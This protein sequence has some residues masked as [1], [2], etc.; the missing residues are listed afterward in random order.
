M[1]HIGPLTASFEDLILAYSVLAGPSDEDPFSVNQPPIHAA[2]LMSNDVSGLRVGVYPEHIENSSPEILESVRAALTF[3]ESRGVVVVNITI[4]HLH[5]INKAHSIVI[6]SEIGGGSFK[7]FKSHFFDY[8]PEVML[9]FG[10][11]RTYSSND[12]IAAQ[13]VRHYASRVMK[14]IFQRVDVI[15]GPTNSHTA[16]PIPSDVASYGESDVTS[17]TKQMAHAPLSNFVG[18]PSLSIPIGYDSNSLPIGLMVEADMWREDLL[19][20]V[21]HVLDESIVSVNRKQ[22]T[23]FSNILSEYL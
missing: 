23:A 6:T 16:F 18:Y 19:F 13:R 17:T 7:Y 4:P 12:L 10:M 2:G 1:C 8:S 15:I 14:D 9:M 3:L 22:P 5:V 20:K 21:A 11:V